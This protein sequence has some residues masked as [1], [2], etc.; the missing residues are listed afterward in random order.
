M[1]LRFPLIIHFVQAFLR[2]F[3]LEMCGAAEITK[4]VK[5]LKT[6]PIIQNMLEYC[7]QSVKEMR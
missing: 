5:L 4:S 3:S 1:F 6:S 7:L 2:R